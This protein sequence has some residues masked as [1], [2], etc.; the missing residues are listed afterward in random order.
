MRD[1]RPLLALTLVLALPQ[2][3]AAQD[4]AN[5]TVIRLT[6]DATPAPVPALKYTLL[7]TYGD[8]QQGSQIPAFY[9]CF[10]EPNQVIS[11]KKALDDREKWLKAPLAELPEKELL[12]YGG[13]ALRQA[14][15]A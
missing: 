11:D 3:G 5:V 14:D 4:D 2:L 9:K 15:Y 7:P 8:M 12:G 6:V 1:R 10:M 13:W